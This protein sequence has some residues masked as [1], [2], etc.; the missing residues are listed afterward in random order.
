MNKIKQIVP[1][2]NPFIYCV[3]ILYGIAKSLDSLI[4]VDSILQ[5]GWN[6][7]K[8]TL[9]DNKA[10]YN[11]GLLFF[12]NFG[13]YYL[14]TLIFY[15]VVKYKRQNVVKNLK[16]QAKDSEIETPENTKKVM[17]NVLRNQLVT[18]GILG[19]AYI[20]DNDF[21]RAR[22]DPELPSLFEVMRHLICCMFIHEFGFYYSH[23]LLHTKWFWRF[24][25]QHHEFKTPTFLISQYSSVF[26]FVVSGFIPI[27][28]GIG[29]LRMHIATALLWLSVV[30]VTL[31]F[32]HMGYH[33]P[34][35]H[36]P[37]MHDNHHLKSNVNFSVYCIADI[38]HGTWQNSKNVE[39]YEKSSNWVPYARIKDNKQG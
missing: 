27:T 18:L 25:K 34:F 30:S 7:V 36:T 38:L 16:L 3:P 13:F 6:K 5:I 35:L 23:R 4:G 22:R 39:D 19:A 29:M 31:T 32:G 8:E 17:L 1:F 24:H 10:Y 9:G 11:V 21:A 26:E 15:L 20:Y 14:Q 28:I 37:Q 2:I 12:Y 33:L